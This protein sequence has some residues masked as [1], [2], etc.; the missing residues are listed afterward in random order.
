[1]RSDR[2]CKNS[3]DGNKPPLLP[4][5]IAF[6]EYAKD[7]EAIRQLLAGFDDDSDGG[8]SWILP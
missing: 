8:L 3:L 4:I 1:M 5:P 6:H 2:S 7:H